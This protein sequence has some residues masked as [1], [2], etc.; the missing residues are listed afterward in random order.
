MH[1]LTAGQ[2]TVENLDPPWAVGHRAAG[3]SWAVGRGPRAVGLSRAVGRGPVFS[4]T[5]VSGMVEN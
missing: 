5:P 1:R 4:K 2:K 3:P